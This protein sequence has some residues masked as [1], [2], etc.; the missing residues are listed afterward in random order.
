M[1]T[2]EKCGA[3]LS[4]YE[5]FCNNCGN[6]VALKENKK[7]V[8]DFDNTILR[9]LGEENLEIK[10]SNNNKAKKNTVPKKVYLALIVPL[11]L[12]VAVIFVNTRGK[13]NKIGNTFQNYD[14]GPKIAKQDNWIYFSITK[15]MNN[16]DTYTEGLYK[17]TI[18]GGV[19]EKLVSDTS[20]YNLSVIGGY[21]YC[22]GDNDIIYKIDIKNK[23]VTSLLD[24]PEALVN[25]N[26]NE[27]PRCNLELV[28]DKEIY[29]TVFQSNSKVL[30][31]MDLNGENLKKIADG[32][33]SIIHADK[34]YIYCLNFPKDYVDA[35][36]DMEFRIVRF[37]RDGSNSEI[38]YKDITKI[39]L[40]IWMEDKGLYWRTSENVLYQYNL[41][42]KEKKIV[43]DNTP[44]SRISLKDGWIYYVE[45]NNLYKRKIDSNEPIK[46]SDE[47]VGDDDFYIFENHILYKN[48]IGKYIVV[49]TDGSEK[50]TF[51]SSEH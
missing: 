46:I 50:A 10:D 23:K 29:F 38:L 41:K 13:V 48:T 15:N 22:Q 47:Q 14:L 34:K 24:K 30:Y 3:N 39:I 25:T 40:G 18:E 20:Y 2:C 11:I 21:I 45:D 16:L 35:N 49:K 4:G 43:L 6:V 31:S 32:H 12:V 37:K 5:Q 42:T 8:E 44:E 17:V 19:P 28:T 51:Q 33:Y 26:D 27:I 9:V 7:D 36:N 1:L